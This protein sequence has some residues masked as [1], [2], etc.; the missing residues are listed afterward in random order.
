MKQ[1]SKP[2]RFMSLM[3]LAMLVWACS[4]EPVPEPQEPEKPEV[5]ETPIAFT[6]SM[7]QEE[8][9]TRA[10]TSPLE[11]F[12]TRFY[13]WGYKND[14]Y[15]EA[16]S[17]YTSYQVVIPGYAVNWVENTAHTTASNTHD[18]EYVGQG[19]DQTIKY[20]DFSAR[21]YRFFATTSSE[22][23]TTK[24]IDGNRV[25]EINFIADAA[26]ESTTP[27]YSKL[28]F[29]NNVD[30]YGKPV[31]LEFLQPFSKVRFMFTYP[32][33]TE[34]NPAP[35]LS[36]PR[37]RPLENSKRIGTK[38]TF[39][40]TYPVTGPSTE[41]KWEIIPTAIIN[42]INS[43]THTWTTTDPYWNTVLPIIGQGAY[44]LTVTVN[45]QDRTCTVP[46][47]YMDWQPGFSYT[48][49]FKVNAEGNVELGSFHIGKT[50]W[51]EGDEAEYILYNW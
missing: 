34:E 15:N 4:Q 51:K 16:T 12:A 17:S 46:A 18:W 32:T 44:K 27:Y 21:A 23:G 26:E 29:S 40:L 2:I 35:S 25:Y 33:P 42:T 30:D 22:S 19:T 39:T 1:I 38:G 50:T 11:N 8:E 5:K 31:T 20:W 3:G 10:A 28:W 47:Q 24:N 6:G 37:F 14:A 13:V 49:I 43:L 48:Y 36:E 9:V 41:L 7:Q 45:G